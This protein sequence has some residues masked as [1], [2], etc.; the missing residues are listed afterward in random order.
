MTGAL[1][2]GANCHG[3]AAPSTRMPAKAGRG[4]GG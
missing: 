1:Q 3:G 4:V 2:A